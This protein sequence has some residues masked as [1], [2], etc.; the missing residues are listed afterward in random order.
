LPSPEARLSWTV[1]DDGIAIV[2]GC[3]APP[4]AIVKVAGTRAWVAMIVE[5]VGGLIGARWVVVVVAAGAVVRVYVYDLRGTR[6]VTAAVLDDCCDDDP[7][8]ASRR[9]GASRRT[10][11]RRLTLSA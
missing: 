6:L 3:S 1:N 2:G 5:R 9:M 7:H 4:G 8:P 10:N 11:I